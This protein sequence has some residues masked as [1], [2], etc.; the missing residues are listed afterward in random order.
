MKSEAVILIFTV[1]FTTFSF[2]QEFG[3]YKV[4]GVINSTRTDDFLTL[5]AQAVNEEEFF[6]NE[7]NYNF[8]VLKKGISGNLSKNNQSSDFSL[9]P[10]EEKQ[11]STIKINIKK[12]EELKVYLFIKHK[13]KLINRDTLFYLQKEKKI[14]KREVN[15]EQ[16]LIRG[17]VIDE[18][19]TKIGK[20][21]HDFFY[22]EYIVTG[23]NYPFIIKIV[24]KP[25]M[26]R[27]SMLSIEVDRKKIHEFFARPEEDYLKYN[28]AK[29][30]EKL[31]VHNQQRK[32]TFQKRI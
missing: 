11:L 8:V 21:Y 32:T 18:A 10:K 29:A 17:I 24:E 25:A 5:R 4:K 1:F 31:R 30:M 3:V 27:S 20:E 26:G 2:G 22:K 7:L 28:V 19:K 12:N 9:K 15:E 23:R 13:G 16:F 6:I 14:A